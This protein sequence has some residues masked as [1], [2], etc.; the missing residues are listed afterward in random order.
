MKWYKNLSTS[1][2]FCEYGPMF[3]L[4]A[5][6]LTKICLNEQI[7]NGALAGC[8]SIY[9]RA[10]LTSQKKEKTTYIV[11]KKGSGKKVS[12]PTGVKGRF[13]AVDAR[14]KKDDRQRKKTDRQKGKKRA[15]GRN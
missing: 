13:K 10:G 2:K 7:T 3:F 1:L 6:Y 8:F 9:K 4:C 11:T 5:F 15:K 12:R 14:Q